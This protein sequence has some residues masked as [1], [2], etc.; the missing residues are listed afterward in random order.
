[1]EKFNAVFTGG[2]GTRNGFNTQVIGAIIMKGVGVSAKGHARLAYSFSQ[3]RAYAP[4]I[5]STFRGVR[6]GFTFASL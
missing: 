1:M 4:P 6:D 2:K 5:I 3:I